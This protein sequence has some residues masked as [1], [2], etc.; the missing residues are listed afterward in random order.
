MFA[1]RSAF[2]RKAF[3]WIAG[4]CLVIGAWGFLSCKSDDG[5]WEDDHELNTNLIGRWHADFEGGYSDDYIITRN[6]ITYNSIFTNADIVFVYN[7]NESKTAGGIIIRRNEADVSAAPY[8]AVWFKDLNPRTSV[9][10]GDAFNAADY[11]VD[12]S[13]ATLEEAKERF[14]FANAATYGGG[15]AQIGSP[16]LWVNP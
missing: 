12:I 15:S 14:K 16:Q 7:F 11:T 13:V 2:P 9:L 10:L 4:L 5:E 8:T 1:I 6:T 3:P